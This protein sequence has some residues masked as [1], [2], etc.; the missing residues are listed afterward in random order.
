VSPSA[1]DTWQFETSLYL[2]AAGMNGWSRLDARTP[3]AK[4]NPCF[5]DIW[6]NLDIGA[7]G[8]FEA[9]KRA[10]GSCSILST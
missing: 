10:G 5:S 1:E 4:I 6:R 7:M 3:T 8:T 9:R 2:W